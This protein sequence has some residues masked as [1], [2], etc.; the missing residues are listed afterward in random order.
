MAGNLAHRRR[1]RQ[2]GMRLRPGL[3]PIHSNCRKILARA[4]SGSE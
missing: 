3:P 4:F 1:G 2:F